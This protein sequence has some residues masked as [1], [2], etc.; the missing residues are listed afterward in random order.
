MYII[1]YALKPLYVGQTGTNFDP[2]GPASFV[3][4]WD[5]VSP[6]KLLS[7]RINKTIK[8]EFPFS[9]CLQNYGIVGIS[10]LRSQLRHGVPNKRS[11]WMEGILFWGYIF[12]VQIQVVE[13]YRFII[14]VFLINNFQV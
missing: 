2:C 3:L 12:L 14:E 11:G 8:K 10:N 13:S 4:L 9:N 7:C 6:P 1:N 5:Q